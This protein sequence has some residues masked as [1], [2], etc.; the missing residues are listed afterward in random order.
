MLKI[1]SKK[2][3]FSFFLSDRKK[4]NSLEEGARLYGGSTQF[5]DG[6]YSNIEGSEFIKINEDKNSISLFVPSTVNVNQQVNNS[7]YVKYCYNKL[8]LLYNNNNITYYDTTG[9]WWSN[10]KND[11]VK[12]DITIITVDMETITENDIYNFIQLAN[13]IKK[14]MSQEGVSIAINAALAII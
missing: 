13:W 5:N 2:F 8:Q 9:S 3:H 11:T 4:V 12:E 1:D 6:I 10:D 7:Y 14:E